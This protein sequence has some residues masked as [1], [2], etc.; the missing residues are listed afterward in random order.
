MRR[1]I[2]HFLK[3]LALAAALVAIL[4]GFLIVLAGYLNPPI[5]A[6]MVWRWVGGAPIETKWVDL[7]EM[8]APLA[9]AVLTAED[10]R[11]CTHAGIDWREVAK[12]LDRPGAARRGA[13]TITMQVAKNLFLWPS[14]SYI[15]KGFEV[16][17]ALAID[18]VWPK[19]RILEVYLN[20]VEWG[21]GIYGASAA[22]RVHF[23]KQIGALTRGE[24]ALL[25]AS[26]PAP[27]RR[28]AGR[29]GPTT[30]A[31]AARILQRMKNTNGLFNCVR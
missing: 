1:F 27:L 24:A 6:L 28:R 8:P 23:G 5:S 12:V 31:G 25:A 15:R 20:I 22:A 21:P 11:F 30:R 26:L 7:H 19:R 3:R 10:N 29:P 13:S 18:L 16:P 2:A 14:R 9:Q 17:I 4:V